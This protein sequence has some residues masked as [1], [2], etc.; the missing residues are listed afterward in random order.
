MQATNPINIRPQLQAFSLTAYYFQD[1]ILPKH[2]AK[3]VTI[4]TAFINKKTDLLTAARLTGKE[5]ELNELFEKLTSFK[6]R[7]GDLRAKVIGKANKTALKSQLDSADRIRRINHEKLLTKF[8]SEVEAELEK[9]SRAIEFL[10]ECRTMRG[11]VNE[12]SARYY[13]DSIKTFLTIL[14]YLF[15]EINEMI[16]QIENS[17]DGL[18]QNAN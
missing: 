18:L 1:D 7:L 4:K 9:L 5:N 11:T 6:K 10:D 13:G 16:Q 3:M 17:L 8:E 2:C 15:G 14:N 12:L